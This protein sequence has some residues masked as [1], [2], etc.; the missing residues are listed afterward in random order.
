MVRRVP[1]KIIGDVEHK[2]CCRCAEWL[3]ISDFSKNPRAW[4]NMLARCKKCDGK[5]VKK[6]LENPQN[7]K[8]RKLYDAIYNRSKKGKKRFKKYNESA[9][10]R[11]KRRIHK[12]R[13]REKNKHKLEWKLRQYMSSRACEIYNKMGKTKKLST[14]RMFG[15]DILQLRHHIE[16]QFLDYMNT[17]N[18]RI[19]GWHIDHRV[20][21]KA[22][23]LSK[24]LDQ[25]VCFWYK[26]L[27]PMWGKDNIE[28]KDK[29]KEEDKQALIKEWIFYNI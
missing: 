25:R 16:K 8:R 10:G 7:R 27:Q 5:R 11:E 18:H 13:H 3:N 4:D 24:P 23:D 19:N 17:S 15:C 21:C 9:K 29:Y 12:K 26:N 6:S 20:P 14:V 2:K 1:H 28:K 22:F